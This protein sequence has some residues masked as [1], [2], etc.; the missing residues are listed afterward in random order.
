[1]LKIIING[2]RINVSENKT[3]LEVAKKNNI[4]I[5]TLCYL[6]ECGHGDVCGVCLVEIEGES[7][8]VRACS[9]KVKDG[10]VIKT[11]SERVQKEVRQRVSELLDEHN[12][13]CGHCKRLGNCE[14]FELVIRV[15]AKK[16]KKTNVINAVD[17]RSKSIIYDKSKCLRCGR[18]I[19]ECKKMSG[20]ETIKFREIDGELFVG[21]E[22][23]KCFDDTGCILCGQC[24]S[25]CP[26]DALSEKSHLERVKD[27][28][29]DKNKHVLVAMAP[30][31]RTALGELLG[32]KIGTDVTGK[33]YTALR[34][35]GFDKIFDTNFGA[36]MTIMEE[37]TELLER[38]KNNGPFPM[39]TSCCPGWIRLVEN[40]YP[41]F[42]DNISSAK[43]PNQMFGAASKTYYPFISK[44]SPKDV[45]TV[46]I[47]PCVAKKYEI[48]RPEMVNRGEKNIDASLTTRELVN[49]IK[50]NQIDFKNLSNGEVDLAMGDY[51]GAGTI[52]GATGG[53]MEAALRTAKDLADGV[54]LENV[55]YKE[56]RGLEGIKEATVELG[57]REYNIAVINGAANFFK[58]MNEG[59][60]NSKQYHFIEVMACVGGCVNG[61]GQPQV[62]SKVRDEIKFRKLRASVLYN[63]DANLLPYR[64]SHKN[65]SLIKM[66]EDYIGKVGGE[67]AHEL[68]HV[69]YKNND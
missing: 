34:M 29:N 23:L 67:I 39:F 53:V 27:A 6:K 66:Y 1:M 62:S 69:S 57:G 50:E 48:D 5:A 40:Y 2:K 51:T 56:V 17:L 26:V 28:L 25:V 60:I 35:L 13:D 44:I 59:I 41:E 58:F 14:F 24:V 63:Q 20:T 68:F 33:A 15:G 18:C 10:M 32:E 64:K 55:E 38:I 52:F 9:T 45:F 3:I 22:G 4:D 36:D 65:K 42:L 19:E 12:Y 30:S 61:G 47:M 37:G 7:E 16:H 21:A 31:V 46:S 43:S 49:L 8:L 11:K 54:S